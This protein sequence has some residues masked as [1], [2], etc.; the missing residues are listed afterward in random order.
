MPTEIVVDDSVS[1]AEVLGW[2][3]TLTVVLVSSVWGMLS[4]VLVSGSA[5]T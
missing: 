1:F 2:A 5:L 4:I 3:V